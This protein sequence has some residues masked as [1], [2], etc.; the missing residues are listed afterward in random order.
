MKKSSIAIALVV[1]G[2]Y[3]LIPSPHEMLL[4]P[5]KIPL[6]MRYLDITSTTAFALLFGS[7]RVGGTF[8]IA[9]GVLLGGHQIY[10]RLEVILQTMERPVLKFFPWYNH[11]RNSLVLRSISSRFKRMRARNYKRK[12]KNSF[13]RKK[14]LRK[15]SIIRL[16]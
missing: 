7:C 4:Y 13:S 11:V 2:V 12:Y 14:M 15:F 8:F 3:L 1:I 6:L 16:F 10:H 9:L 5:V